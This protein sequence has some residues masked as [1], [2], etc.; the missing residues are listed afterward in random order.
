MDTQKLGPLTVRRVVRATPEKDKKDE[1]NAPLVCVF[2]HGF[3][4]PGDDLVGLG[5]DLAVPTGTSFLFPEAPL[6]LDPRMP[7]AARAWWPIDVAALERAILRGEER[8]MSGL[9][10]EGLAAAR[11]ALSAMLDAV[12]QNARLVLGGFSQGAMLALDVALHRPELQ[13]A[14]LAI[15]SGTY[16]AEREWK[17]LFPGRKGLRVFQSHGRSDPLLPFSVAERLRR[18]LDFA[19]LEV[20]FDPFEGPHTIPAR[21]S[22]KLGAWLT[23]LR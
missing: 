3:G 18:E 12:D 20:T 13:L 8:D 4:A 23:S 11:A 14:G 16:L 6:A 10:P 2:C 21:T 22:A 17:P 1:G 9:V 15:L 19:G 5:M 7:S